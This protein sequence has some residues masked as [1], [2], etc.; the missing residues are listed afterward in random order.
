VYRVNRNFWVVHKS[1]FSEMFLERDFDGDF[2]EYVIAQGRLPR[3][4][5]LYSPTDRVRDWFSERSEKFN[6]KVRIRVQLLLNENTKLTQIPNLQFSAHEVTKDNFESLAIFD[7]DLAHK[8]WSSSDEFVAC[9]HAVY[10]SDANSKPASLCYAAAIADGRAEIDVIT[11][12]VFRGKGLAKAC[13][14]LFA[15]RCLTA[16]ITPNWDCFIDNHPSLNVALAL[17]FAMKKKYELVSIYQ[18]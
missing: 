13:V 11:R 10:L 17:G 15:K 9:A 5:H 1:G 12:E 6:S 18:K 14:S 7:L 16:G 8:F 3:Y 4:F 2:I